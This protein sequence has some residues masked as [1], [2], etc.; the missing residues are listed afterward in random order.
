VEL[1]VVPSERKRAPKNRFQQPH[2]FGDPPLLN[3]VRWVADPAGY[4][5]ARSVLQKPVTLGDLVA[6]VANRIGTEAN[7]VVNGAYSVFPGV[8][9]AARTVA[10]GTG[11]LGQEEFRRFGQEADVVG[12]ALGRIVRHLELLLVLLAM[13]SPSWMRIRCFGITWAAERPW[14]PS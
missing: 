6:N 11:L 2:P 1:F 3:P 10:R 7:A 9:N 4:G 14:A 13:P 8:Y 12:G 5:N